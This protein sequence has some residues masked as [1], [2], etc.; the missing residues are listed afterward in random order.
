MPQDQI[1]TAR[2]DRGRCD[3]C[4]KPILAGQRYWTATRYPTHQDPWD[5]KTISGGRVSILLHEG[6]PYPSEQ[7][8][9]RP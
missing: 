7:S 3:T 4:R 6:C 1:H 2:K 8:A 5:V 9:P